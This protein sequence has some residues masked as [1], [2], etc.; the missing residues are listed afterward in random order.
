MTRRTQTLP[1]DYFLGIYASDPD[2]WRF[3]TSGS[4]WL[5]WG[6]FTAPALLPRAMD[7]VLLQTTRT[8]VN[9]AVVAKVPSQAVASNR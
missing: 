3:T 6:T 8:E 5:R 4:N 2:P 9:W 1:E 7:S